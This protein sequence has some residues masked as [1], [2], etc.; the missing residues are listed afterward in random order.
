MVYRNPEAA[1][2]SAIPPG[3]R[4][5]VVGRFCKTCYETYPLHR[6]R[7]S[8]KPLYG[9]DHVAS[10]CAHQGDEFAPG[11]AWWEPAVEVLPPPPPPAEA[12]SEASAGSP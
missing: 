3:R 4:G 8:G 11:E 6:L 9:K 10:P 1:P 5:A 2:E 7:H 12:D